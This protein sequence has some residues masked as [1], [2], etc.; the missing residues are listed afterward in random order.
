M[1]N[2]EQRLPLNINLKHIFAKSAEICHLSWKPSTPSNVNN[3]W[4]LTALQQPYKIISILKSFEQHLH[5][6]HAISND[7]RIYLC[8]NLKIPRRFQVDSISF[9]Y[10]FKWNG[11]SE[12]CVCC[13]VDAVSFQQT[14]PTTKYQIKWVKIWIC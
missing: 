7:L 5:G 2:D 12:L 6:C 1:V 4:I 14:F 3:K 8:Y 10:T 9:V 11:C 13:T